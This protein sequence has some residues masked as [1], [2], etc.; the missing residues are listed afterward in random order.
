M[1]GDYL[2]V[3]KV[4]HAYFWQQEYFVHLDRKSIC[5]WEFLNSQ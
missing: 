3:T 1:D 2:G 5:L 4:L